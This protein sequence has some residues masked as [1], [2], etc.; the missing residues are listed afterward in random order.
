MPSR[1]IRTSTVSKRSLI[2]SACW[3][4]D[5]LGSTGVPSSDLE[6]TALR[7]ALEVLA[8]CGGLGGDCMCCSAKRMAGE[9]DDAGDASSKNVSNGGNG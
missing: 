7:L 6:I 1:L 9:R 5:P 4:L 8:G 3:F 2:S